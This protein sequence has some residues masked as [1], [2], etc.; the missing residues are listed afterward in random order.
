MSDPTLF[1]SEYIVSALPLDHIDADTFW[2]KVA[3]RGRR[4]LPY[5]NP[6]CGEWAVTMRGMCLDDRDCWDFEPLPSSRTPEWCDHHRF[7]LDEAVKAAERMLHTVTV[8]GRFVDVD[9]QLSIR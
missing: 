3:W 4:R 9:G 5:S 6:G 7:T 2:I 8:N 1:A